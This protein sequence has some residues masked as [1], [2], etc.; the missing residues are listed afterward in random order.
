MPGRSAKALALHAEADVDS[1]FWRPPFVAAFGVA[2]VNGFDP[3]FRKMMLQQSCIEVASAML[4][5]DDVGGRMGAGGWG[6]GNVTRDL[7]DDFA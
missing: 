1:R 6:L 2:F 5:A 4:V 3:V 7:V